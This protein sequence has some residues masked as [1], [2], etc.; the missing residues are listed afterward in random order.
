MVYRILADLV[1][2]V[3]LAF[4]L[5]VALGGFLVLRRRSVAWFHLPAA[6]WGVLIEFAGWVCPL[7]PLEVELRLRGGEAGYEGGFVEHYILPLLYPGNLTRTLQVLL[8]VL[9]LS[10]NVWIYVVVVR[11][12]V[13][14]RRARQPG[15]PG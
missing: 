5:F 3:H 11:R 15:D 6:A 10:V 8:G 7:T 12:A 1:V 14:E 9:A 4:V 2:S 13:R